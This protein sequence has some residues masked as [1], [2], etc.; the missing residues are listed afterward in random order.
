[1][2]SF[3]LA[4]KSTMTPSGRSTEKRLLHSCI[5]L[6]FFTRPGVSFFP[7]RYILNSAPVVCCTS[8]LFLAGNKKDLSASERERREE[9][10]RRRQRKDDVIIGKTSAKKGEKDFALDP[11]A[12]E[13]EY[14]RYASSVERE[15]FR[16]TDAGMQFL[17]SVSKH[18]RRSKTRHV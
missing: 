1:M 17:N 16:L 14:L 13:Q 15:V 8:S 7:S 6:L 9:E 3:A 2:T 10:E 4:L 12:T 18:S 5:L 11:K